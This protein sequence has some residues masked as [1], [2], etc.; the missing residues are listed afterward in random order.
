MLRTTATKCVFVTLYVTYCEYWQFLDRNFPRGHHVDSQICAATS[1]RSAPFPRECR[2]V[3]IR[4]Y[5]ICVVGRSSTRP[6]GT[7]CAGTSRAQ[8]TIEPS[9][10]LIQARNCAPLTYGR[11]CT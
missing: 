1:K 2:P 5:G 3:V 6:P 10:D 11:S 8:L 7:F 4:A 9:G